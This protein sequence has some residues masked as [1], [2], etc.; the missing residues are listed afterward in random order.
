MDS[1]TKWTDLPVPA[2]F[3]VIKEGTAAVLV[4]DGNQV[5]YNEVQE[6]NRDLSILVISQFSTNE[7]EMRSLKAQQWLQKGIDYVPK[8]KRNQQDGSGSSPSPNS[9]V[10]T[11][12]TAD[13]AQNDE[14]VA[15]PSKKQKPSPPLQ[16]TPTD[17]STTTTTTLTTTNTTNDNQ[18]VQ[19]N[20]TK[21]CQDDN[22]PL[23]YQYNGVRIFEALSASGL[24]SIRYFNEI[25]YVDTIHV[26]DMD[27]E[28]VES[29]RRNVLYNQLPLERVIPNRNE[30]TAALYANRATTRD[31]VKKIKLHSD[32]T[33][34]PQP[35]NIPDSHPL[36]FLYKAQH[37]NTTSLAKDYLPTTPLWNVV[38]LDP[39]G[40]ASPFLDA[41]LQA[42]QD[43]G[44]LC[45][46]CTD[47]AV[48]CGN[49]L[50]TGFGKYNSIPLH[51]NDISKEFGLR[52][53]LHTIESTAS[54]YGRSITPLLSLSI[55][56]YMRVFVKVTTSPLLVK[57]S[58]SRHAF[59]GHCVG[60]RTTFDS[61]CMVA[62]PAYDPNLHISKQNKSKFTHGTEPL[63]DKC[64]ICQCRIKVCGPIWG[65]EIHNQ[66]FVKQCLLTL[67]HRQYR[68]LCDEEEKAK[69]IQEDKMGENGD[70]NGDG[71]GEEKKKVELKEPELLA[72]TP[73]SLQTKK[74]GTYQRIKG[75]LTMAYSELP[76]VL[77]LPLS[78]I[79]QSFCIST[80]K[81]EHFLSAF[82]NA[83]YLV[84]ETHTA[85]NMI[86]TNAPW[87]FY[88]DVL[89]AY[90]VMENGTLN[91]PWVNCSS[92]PR[93]YVASDKV[94]DIE[95]NQLTF[96]PDEIEQKNI[97]VA[98]DKN[99]TMLNYFEQVSEQSSVRAES[100]HGVDRST[101]E[102]QPPQKRPSSQPPDA[103][104]CAI[105]YDV[106]ARSVAKKPSHQQELSKWVLSQPIT[107]KINFKL[108]QRVKI[109]VFFLNPTAYWGP[110]AA[111]GSFDTRNYT[112][113]NIEQTE[114][115]GDVEVN[116]KNISRALAFA[117]QQRSMENQGTRKL[118][119]KGQIDGTKQ[120]IKE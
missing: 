101:V 9:S 36:A 91:K 23:N 120:E 111:A 49:Y 21:A 2:G 70:G 61:R 24:R 30:A 112:N 109:P 85:P 97:F 66:H 35:E 48:L 52:M 50:E 54:K 78:S 41:A 84:S 98:D 55:D 88:I 72:L 60:C 26:N 106:M 79:S 82:L 93:A 117:Q 10:T 14:D 15:Q 7:M 56:F 89:R 71:N 110:K 16:P 42:V 20:S 114:K 73:V 13:V 69:L 80:P 8:H 5:F 96:T 1:N 75:M 17:P 34:P 38:D 27:T 37:G 45:V 25:P 119:N 116:A 94:S 99:A 74:F 115:G 47:G 104:I 107:H 103:N 12:G 95:G 63:P 81:I 31:L 51:A 83:G 118:K 39:Y 6:F 64:P 58:G 62:T 19:L 113:L 92:A 102:D 43:D 57:F 46:T 105:K 100:E 32:S 65:D 68:G 108:R 77:G 87:Q 86:K 90:V 18:M 29:I 33:L 22:L 53:L 4:P 67:E 76:T 28:A 40:S 3:N 44:L 11:V 59:V